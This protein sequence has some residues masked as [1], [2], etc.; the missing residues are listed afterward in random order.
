MLHFY[1]Y[2]GLPGSL[3]STEIDNFV[4]DNTLTATEVVSS[5]EIRLERGY[6]AGDIKD[7]FEIARNR[8]LRSKAVN[9]IFDATN[10]RRKHRVTLLDKVKHQYPN[11]TTHLIFHALP[12]KMCKYFNNQRTGFDKVPEHVYDRM[13]RN[14]D[15]PVKEE[16]WDEVVYKTAID[17]EVGLEG[18]SYI[19]EEFVSVHG[20]DMRGFNQDNP[21]HTLDLNEHC[22]ATLNYV[23]NHYKGFNRKE[24]QILR[25]A[26]AYHDIGKLLTKDY[27]TASG[28]P[29]DIAHYYGHENVGAYLILSES[30]ALETFPQDM[31]VTIAKLVNFHMKISFSWNKAPYSKNT[32]NGKA[33]LT[34][35]ELLMLELLGEADRQA[36]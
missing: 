13:L 25:Y 34:T 16:G 22:Q 23:I 35:R 20:Y 29:C 15:M 31:V 19:A 9:V 10:L 26:A 11:V 28:K 32:I 6:E 24:Q 33:L 3:K 12:I 18:Y 30:T 8:I 21:H 17:L 2:C 27:H 5:D 1:M 14:F 7:V 36:H 4:K